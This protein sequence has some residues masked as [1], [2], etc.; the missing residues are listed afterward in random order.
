MKGAQILGILTIFLYVL[1]LFLLVKTPPQPFISQQGDFQH[2]TRQ[3][4]CTLHECSLLTRLA[5]VN[6]DLI[7]C[8]HSFTVSKSVIIRLRNMKAVSLHCNL[9]PVP[10]P[11]R[12]FV[13]SSADRWKVVSKFTF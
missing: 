7:G 8:A 3:L 1:Q 11:V 13:C 2:Y 4:H 5:C 12:W 6:G 9:T 10:V